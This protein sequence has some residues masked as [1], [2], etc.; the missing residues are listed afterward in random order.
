MRGES[1][2]GFQAVGRAAKVAVV[3]YVAWL[4]I[5]V[6]MLGSN[7]ID[8]DTASLFG[9]LPLW[10]PLVAIAALSAAVWVQ[11]RLKR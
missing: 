4:V 2:L 3:F 10:G 5:F 1:A 11:R 6:L 9:L 7:R 8:R